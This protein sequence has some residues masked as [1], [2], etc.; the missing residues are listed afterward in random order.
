MSGFLKYLYADYKVF[1]LLT[2]NVK[3]ILIPENCIF[4]FYT[5]KLRVQMIVKKTMMITSITNEEH[6]YHYHNYDRLTGCHRN[7]LESK[8]NVVCWQVLGCF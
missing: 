3:P 5:K 6:N 7:N 2:G 4:T 1:F 8:E